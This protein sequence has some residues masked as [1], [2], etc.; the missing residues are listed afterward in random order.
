[1]LSDREIKKKLDEELKPDITS[2][3]FCMNAG[4]TFEAQPEVKQKSKWGWLTKVFAPIASVA[5][6]ALCIVLPIT[7]RGDDES[8]DL[9]KYGENEV[10]YSMIDIEN[11]YAEENFF[12]YNQSFVYEEGVAYKITPTDTDMRLG[13]RISDVIYADASDS[14]MP[15]FAFEFDYLIRCYDG[16][17]ISSAEVYSNTDKSY[18]QSGISF[19]YSIISDKL[20]N[21]AYI[22]F[23]YKK[24]D[25]YIH[26][27]SFGDITEINEDNVQLFIQKAFAEEKQNDE[28]VIG[29]QVDS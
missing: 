8:S 19:N 26:V 27:R 29:R 13:Y 10:V 20:G 4:I 18:S 25:Y 3:R 5:A 22:S 9:P 2:D 1:M 21:F 12:M 7:L 28:A 17:T 6:V 23:E 24:Y 15:N 11:V 16:Y 14:D